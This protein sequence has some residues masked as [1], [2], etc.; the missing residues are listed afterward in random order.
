MI[1][2]L[3]RRDAGLR[4]SLLLG[5]A[6]SVAIALFSYGMRPHLVRAG[7]IAMILP[8]GAAWA[9][10]FVGGSEARG[11]C[12]AV[13]MWPV[14][15]T[16]LILLRTLGVLLPLVLFLGAGTLLVE[17]FFGERGTIPLLG[18]NV[19]AASVAS[20][21][22]YSLLSCRSARWAGGARALLAV[23]F[24]VVA[25][26]VAPLAGS[27]LFAASFGLLSLGMGVLLWRVTPAAVEVG[28]GSAPLAVRVPF[29]PSTYSPLRLAVRHW[30][31]R[32]GLPLLWLI[33]CQSEVY[34]WI[35]VLIVAAMALVL[36][37]IILGGAR[38]VLGNFGGLPL[39]RERI[40]PLL[41]L[42][43][44]A[45]PIAVLAP[46]PGMIGALTLFRVSCFILIWWVAMRG[47]FLGGWRLWAPP[48][49]LIAFGLLF[50][51]AFGSVGSDVSRFVGES[52]EPWVAYPVVAALAVAA[53]LHGQRAFLRMEAG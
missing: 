13:A 4:L 44:I 6:L 47:A 52:A 3:L 18:V 25:V 8:V 45:V 32:S 31:P 53:Y 12:A 20:L 51:Q 43:P 23:L 7:N 22:L 21:L 1:L 5:G 28:A 42:P 35:P 37:C 17:H 34:A 19:L 16:T 48:L 50:P 39:S 33:L 26:G 27:F 9:S 46:L 2:A 49:G 30:T 11:Y 38:E 10:A 29:P 40:F 41:A 15:G 14:R 36:G 24:G